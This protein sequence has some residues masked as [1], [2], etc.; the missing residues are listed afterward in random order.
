MAL[1][2]YGI[3]INSLMPRVAR[4]NRAKLPQPVG[5]YVYCYLRTNSNRPYYV[6]QGSRPDRMTA[7][8]TCKVPADRSRIRILRESLTKEQADNWEIFYIERY[9]RKSEGG[10]LVNHREG[11][12][13]GG[14]DEETKARISVK[15]AALHEQGA[16]ESLN[17][18]ET[19]ERR[20]FE[21]MANKAAEFGI[22]AE[23]YAAM[24]KN[25]RQQC[26][27]WLTANPGKTYEEWLASSKSALA[28]AKYGLTQEEWEAL[29]RKQKN[30][31]KEWM[32]RWPGRDARDWLAGERAKGGSKA[33]ID[34]EQVFALKAEG[35]S[36]T[37]IAKRLGCQQA[38]VSRIVNGLR[39]A[40]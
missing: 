5:C 20:A 1:Y 25:R 10:C 13:R 30:C 39:Q 8:H 22:P 12:H 28:A 33:R 11:G 37:E 29:D 16:Y 17:A 4:T 27:A 21:R 32:L 15:V 35:L 24:T 38:T 19:V 14:N 9:G 7:K 31:L 23:D 18:P 36:Q 6:G 34:K 40:A 3:P 26:K 2:A